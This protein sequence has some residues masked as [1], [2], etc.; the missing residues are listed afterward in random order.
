MLS[1]IF[2]LAVCGVGGRPIGV[3]VDLAGGLPSFTTVGLPDTAVRESKDRVLAAI[4]NS[5]FDFP[6]KK[7]TVNLSPSELRKSGTQYDLAMALG[8]LCASGQIKAEDRHESFCFLGELALDG[9]LQPVRGVLPMALAAKKAGFKALVV[10]RRNQ[11]EARLAEVEV[12]GAQSLREAADFLEGKPGMQ[13][14][15]PPAA[16][17]GVE[18][19][20]APA[21]DLSEVRGQP[22]AKRALEIAAAGGHNLLFIGPPG[23]GK[24]M[25][26][27]R[28]P[29]VLPPLSTS[30]ALEVAQIHSVCGLFSRMDCA[31]T[32]RPFRSPHHTVSTAALVGGGS[33]PRP[34]E[35]SLAHR[36][37][38]F[39]DEL[40][41][42]HRDALEAL[43]E[44]LEAAS[45]TVSRA[46]DVEVFP[47]DFMLVAAMNPCPCG[48]LGHPKKNCL[49]TPTQVH[50]YRSRV[51]GPL[52]DR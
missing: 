39:L 18:P 21:E 45:V 28:L 40:P 6:L 12:Y 34:G 49:C 23:T 8:I 14:A 24:S 36:G 19:A 32:L 15:A 37:V 26:A 44:P 4:R 46:K 7:I 38:L 13:P 50:K 31:L 47:A 29:G 22:L 42:F 20:A 27:R 33:L 51:S 25:L 3:E 43:R 35:V 52:W 1:K 16:A 9:R 11:G 41:E 2:S 17:L 30:E 10:P 48:Y 5:G